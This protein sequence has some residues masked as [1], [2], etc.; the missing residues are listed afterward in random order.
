MEL[1]YSRK[2]KLKYTADVLVV[3]GGPS[4]VAAAV[5]CA[6]EKIDK[7]G[8]K[9][10]VMLIEQ[11]GSLG[12]S[13]VL[14][15][16][17]EIMNFDDG[18]NFLAGGFGKEVHDALFPP[19]RYEREWQ[20]LRPEELKRLY[21]RLVTEAGVKLSFYTRLTDAVCKGDKKE[22][23]Y[24]TVSTPEGL[25][26]IR[27]KRYIDCTGN[28]LL[29][30]LA[31]AESEYG[32]GCGITMATTLCSLFGGVD[33]ENLGDQEVNLP[34]AYEDGALP[35]YDMVLPGIKA[36]FPEISVGGGNVGHCFGVD[37]RCA[38][39][40]T[41]A[42][43]DGRKML[44]AYEKYYR[45]YVKGAENCTLIRTADYLGVRESRR[46]ICEQMLTFEAYNRKKPFE[47]EIGRYSYP[48]DIH[49]TSSDRDGM[50][51]FYTSACIQHGD[52][53]SY[54]IPLGCLIPK[55]YTNLLVAGRCIGADREMQASVR[56]IPGCYITGQGAGIAAAQSLEEDCTPINADIKKLKLR[57]KNAGAYLV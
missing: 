37:D 45:K 50:K 23:D 35:H 52:G 53:E 28:A 46:V 5:M 34:R 27:A 44:S 43:V 42:M 49:P 32:D 17:P 10:L 33:F 38:E 9:P 30:T 15:M 54:S 31:G 12:G 48:I 20:N 11:S 13:S 16:V 40:L 19:C 8:K 18:K 21:D 57:L 51:V 14:S 24:V 26:A 3:G 4:G 6:R 1:D 7:N 41:E 36:N 29:C 47:N 55:G 56:V 39:S 22:I 25:F 2:I